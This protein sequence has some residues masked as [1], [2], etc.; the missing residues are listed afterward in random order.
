M[1]LFKFILK[2]ISLDTPP[3]TKVF[4]KG[5]VKTKSSS[6]LLTKQCC[7]VLG[8]HVDYLVQ[9]WRTAKD[10]LN[11]VRNNNNA[12][13]DGAVRN[14]APPPWVPF[15]AKQTNR[16]DTSKKSL[17]Q[18]TKEDDGTSEFSQA[19][20]AALAAAMQEKLNVNK[21]FIQQ[22]VQ[23]PVEPTPT[24][25]PTRPLS[26]TAPVASGGRPERRKFI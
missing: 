2:L 13:G 1:I 5:I 14:D 26:S 4:L 24:T 18:T 22:S 11:N 15:G 20:Q 12:N 21:T 23:A 10:I 19:R 7:Q 8:G 16:V 17:Q 9:K 25:A 3:G 6:L